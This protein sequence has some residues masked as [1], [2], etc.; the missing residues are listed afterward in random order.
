MEAY[1]TAIALPCLA[2][3][4]EENG[5]DGEKGQGRWLVMKQ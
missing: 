4:M 1:D 3:E 5:V 2:K